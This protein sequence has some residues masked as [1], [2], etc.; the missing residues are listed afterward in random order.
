MLN[1]LKDIWH[2][3]KILITISLTVIIFYFFVVAVYL[4]LQDLQIVIHKINIFCEFLQN[5]NYQYLKHY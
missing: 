4:C 3:C 1:F 5:V 2:L